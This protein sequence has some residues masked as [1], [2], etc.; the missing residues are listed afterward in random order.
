MIVI[1]GDGGIGYHV[2]DLETALRCDLP[3]VVVVGQ[4]GAWGIEQS[5]QTGVYGGGAEF[6]S[7]LTG[8][9][10]TLVAR[11]FGVAAVRADGPEALEGALSDAI[12]ARRPWLVQVAIQNRRSSG[13]DRLIQSLRAEVERQPG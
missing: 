10:F 5:L 13:T 1:A 3:V 12:A 7:D 9:D 4:D 2:A 8:T 6:T 11:G